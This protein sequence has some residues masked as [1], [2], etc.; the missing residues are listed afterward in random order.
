MTTILV[1]GGA[2]FIGSHT[3][4]ALAAQG[5]QPVAFDNMSKG[6]AEF[7]RWGPSERGDILDPAHLDAAFARHRP[8]AV[9]H[10]A[11]LAY[12]GPVPKHGLEH[13][14]EALHI[15]P[16]VGKGCGDRFTDIGQGGEMDHGARP[17]PRKCRI[18][19]RG[20]ENVAPF[21][22]SPTD[23]F[24]MPFRHVVEGNGEVALRCQRLAG[25][26]ADEA[27]ASCNENCCHRQSTCCL[28]GTRMAVT[29][30]SPVISRPQG[31]GGREVQQAETGKKRQ[32]VV[33]RNSVRLLGGAR[34]ICIP[35]FRV[36]GV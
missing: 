32:Q 24:G 5:Y 25:V 15:D 11:A 21:Q 3:F 29:S 1:T 14:D 23:E 9:I 10:F 17:M 16:I 36:S 2:G 22:R 30:A 27:G 26:T 20:I 28:L 6:Q 33:D 18:E 4:K 35:W 19:M 7:V 31:R 8:S 34:F 12:V 13:I